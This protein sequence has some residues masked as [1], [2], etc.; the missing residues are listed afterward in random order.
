M[1]K[2]SSDLEDFNALVYTALNWIPVWARLQGKKCKMQS[3]TQDLMDMSRSTVEPVLCTHP[4]GM[5]K[6][7]LNTGW[8]PNTGCK[9]YSLKNSTSSV[10]QIRSLTSNGNINFRCF[11]DLRKYTR[12]S[13]VVPCVLHYLKLYEQVTSLVGVV[14]SEYIY[15][16]HIHTSSLLLVTDYYWL[17]LIIIDFCYSIIMNKLFFSVTSISIDFHYKSIINDNQH[18]ITIEID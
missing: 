3:M 15:L 9:K 18:I 16:N 5:A 11:N 13:T 17:L 2:D 4:R 7:P 8:L 10:D 14:G 12:K 6:W 1:P